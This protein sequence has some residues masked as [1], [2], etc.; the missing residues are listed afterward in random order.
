MSS[1][2]RSL[3]VRALAVAAAVTVAPLALVAVAGVR[4]DQR[5]ADLLAKVSAARGAAT[6]I[7]QGSLPDALPTRALEQAAARHDVWLRV[8]GP[9]DAPLLDAD[10]EP[11]RRDPLILDPSP[12]PTPHAFDRRQG[13]LAARPEVLAARR[14]APQAECVRSVDDRLLSCHATGAAGP[15]V[16]QARAVSYRSIRALVDLEWALVKVTLLVLPGALLLAWWLAWRMVRPIERLRRHVLERAA[17]PAPRPSLPVDRRD[18]LGDLATA[19]NRL[20]ARLHEESQRNMAFVQDL[21]HEFKNPV[22]AIRASAEAL[23][24]GPPDEARVLRLARVLDAS[25]QRLDALLTDLMELAAA[26]GGMPGEARGDVDLSALCRGLLDAMSQDERHRGVTFA[27]R[28]PE[29]CLV[30]G[31]PGRLETAVR[32]LLDNAATFAAQGEQH[33][34][35][36]ELQRGRAEVTLTVRDD[37]PGVAPED[38]PRI[39]DRF[40]THR[41]QGT[42]LGLALVEAVVAAHG[43]DVEARGGPGE[44]AVF[45]VRLPAPL[46]SSHELHAS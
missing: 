35:Q 37:G 38:L 34:V 1:G 18:E 27:W 12:A 43:G 25:G 41:A 4:E 20:L 5:Q 2:W 17:A 45:V 10:H 39:F 32:N 9:D 40:F 24:S 30:P 44:G 14:G 31:V 23:A 42:G 19:F 3:R 28:G 46:A 16:V 22:A 11:T 26:E 8:L 36:V 6:S 33:I 7:L 15:F 21:A 13:P 29:R